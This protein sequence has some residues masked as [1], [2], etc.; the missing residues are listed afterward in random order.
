MLE[1]LC[2][3]LSVCVCCNGVT[4]WPFVILLQFTYFSSG[5]LY[6]NLKCIKKHVS[7][8][9]W[10]TLFGHFRWKFSILY[11]F[12]NVMFDDYKI[13]NTV[14]NRL[15]SSVLNIWIA[16]S[17]N[18]NQLKDTGRCSASR[19]RVINLFQ[20]GK[21]W[22]MMVLMLMINQMM[23][24]ITLWCLWSIQAEIW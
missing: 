12:V 18:S 1:G 21:S 24:K 2:F 19:K 3:R 5:L 10:K 8:I 9:S 23:M 13:D 7:Y 16:G 20:N 17:L 15:L 22:P 14:W 4:L 6:F 11:F